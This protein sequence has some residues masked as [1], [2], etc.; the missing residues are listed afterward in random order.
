MLECA[1]WKVAPLSAEH[2]LHRVKAR[3]FPSDPLRRAQG[4]TRKN[5][6]AARSVRQL[7]SFARPGKAHRMIANHLALANRL[8]WNLIIELSRCP[9]NFRERFRRA[10]GRILFHAVMGLNNSQIEFW[11]ENFSS[12]A[13]Q[14]EKR[15]HADAEVGC[16]NNR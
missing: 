16:E 5:F 1:T 6:A 14:S 4:A 3:G 10:A 8:N 13:R 12:F 11:S 15:V 7:E 2:I 9:Q